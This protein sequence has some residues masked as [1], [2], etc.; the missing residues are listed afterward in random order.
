MA[1][2]AKQRHDTVA[3]MTRLEARWR[4]ALLTAMIPG[5]TL[6]GLHAVD[7]APFWSRFGRS[8]PWLLRLGFRVAIVVLTWQTVLPYGKPFHRLTPDRQDASLAAAA[9]S[10][11]YMLR[12]LV[13]V[14]KLI[15]CFG[16]FR[17]PSVH[18]AVRDSIGAR[19]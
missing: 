5:G 15:A 8:S 19:P 4:D 14:V 16:Y 9:E 2:G 17:D 12:Q 18:T 6:T 1:C 10:R 13:N 3:T 11:S 7:L